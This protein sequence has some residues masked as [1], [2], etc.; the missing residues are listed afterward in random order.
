[1]NATTEPKPSWWYENRWQLSIGAG[2]VLLLA[3]PATFMAWATYVMTMPAISYSKME[4]LRSGMTAAE[5]RDLLGEPDNVLEQSGGRE[6]WRYC[7]GTWAM[8]YIE[9]DADGRITKHWHDY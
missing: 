5:V 4:R 1:M 6:Q 3:P 8:Y 9:L 7:P 2:I